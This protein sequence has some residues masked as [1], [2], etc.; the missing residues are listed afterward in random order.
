ML[1]GNQ[2]SLDRV[3]MGGTKGGK[4][5]RGGRG[6]SQKSS[7]NVDKITQLIRIYFHVRR[8]EGQ[9]KVE[10]GKICCRKWTQPSRIGVC[11]FV[12][13]II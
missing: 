4:S 3:K 8:R 11:S 10:G 1:N 2:G 5:V 9:R 13:C 12:H 7:C 6:K